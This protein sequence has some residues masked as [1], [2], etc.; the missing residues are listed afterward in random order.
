MFLLTV[1]NGCEG[2]ECPLNVIIISLVILLIIFC[3][4]VYPGS[5]FFCKKHQKKICCFSLACCGSIWELFYYDEN[6]KDKSTKVEEEEKEEELIPMKT[7]RYEMRDRKKNSSMNDD[8][9]F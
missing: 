6:K 2:F 4:G 3:V 7:H 8:L 1:S 5:C 9:F